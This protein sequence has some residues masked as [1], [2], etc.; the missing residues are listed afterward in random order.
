LFL[1]GGGVRLWAF[2]A[3]QRYWAFTPAA[4]Y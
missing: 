2:A 4:W 1:W 3:S